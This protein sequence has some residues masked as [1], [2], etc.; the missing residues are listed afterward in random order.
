M[1]LSRAEMRRQVRDNRRKWLKRAFWF[2]TTVTVAG[3][4]GAWLWAWTGTPVYF[5]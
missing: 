2:V 4:L 5:E 3:T 1:S